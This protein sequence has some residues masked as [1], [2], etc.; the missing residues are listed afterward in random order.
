VNVV[1]TALL[2]LCCCF[3]AAAHDRW[4]KDTSDETVTDSQA[5]SVSVLS[6]FVNKNSTIHCIQH[7]IMYNICII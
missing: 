3:C 5:W 2:A 1:G 6:T 4:Q 7:Q